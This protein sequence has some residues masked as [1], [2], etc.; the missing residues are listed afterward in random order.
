MEELSKRREVAEVA[1]PLEEVAEV[2]KP[3]EERTQRAAA[4]LCDLIK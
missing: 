4:W 1:K 2:A 3:I